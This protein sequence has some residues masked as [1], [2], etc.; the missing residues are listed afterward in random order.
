MHIFKASKH[1]NK[2]VQRVGRGGSRGTSSGRGT[3]GQ[4]SRAGH[5]IR[6]A[7]RDL[8]I[9]IPKLR[10]YRNKVFRTKATVINV[11][12]VDRMPE[13]V[14]TYKTVGRVKILGTGELKKSIT[15][16]GLT[17][18]KSA[19]AKI[20]KAGGTVKEPIAKS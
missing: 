8:L 13:T 7:E 20:E 15:V 4:G 5:R 10:G 6:P 12:D 14:F 3:K 1:K 11:G 18:S 16:E 2:R 19:R 9:R 17:V